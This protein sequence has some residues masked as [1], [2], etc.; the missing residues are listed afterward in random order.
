MALK[1]MDRMH[2]KL[3]QGMHKFYLGCKLHRQHA[4]P[5]DNDAGMTYSG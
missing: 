2:F 3:H 4:H 1:V 5:C